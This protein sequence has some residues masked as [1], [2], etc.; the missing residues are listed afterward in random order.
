M[1]SIQPEWLG[2]INPAAA[3]A[4]AHAGSG[5]TFTLQ[6]WSRRGMRRSWQVWVALSLGLM[7]CV[8]AINPRPVVRVQPT[9]TPGVAM[10]LV[11]PE[12]ARSR[13]PTELDRGAEYILLCDGRPADGMRCH[14]LPEVGVD[15]RSLSVTPEAL[16]PTVDLGV[17]TLADVE[18]S[19]SRE[20]KGEEANE[21]DSPVEVEPTPTDAPSETE[22]P[23]PSPA[24][25]P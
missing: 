25:A 3:V 5:L 24:S 7:G 23:P 8:P 10:V 19:H 20:E 6:P 14:I 11:R 9:R 12:F 4:L 17:A 13:G 2:F 16:G 1:R 22:P 15:R 21:G 18:L